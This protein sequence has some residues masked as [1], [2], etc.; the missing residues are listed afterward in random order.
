[1]KTRAGSVAFALL[2]VGVAAC[3]GDGA[4]TTSIDTTMPMETTMA[5]DMGDEEF[6]FG[7]PMDGSMADRVVEITANDDFTFAPATIEVAN[8]EV[9]TF[10]VTNTGS[11]PHD[12]VLGDAEAQDEHAAEMAEM[13]A[14]MAHDEANVFTLAPGET[15]ELTWHFTVSGEVIYGCHQPG[16]YTAGM[17]GTVTVAG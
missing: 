9:V 15:K 6:A 17:K 11:I 12:F 1:M 10:R 2:L 7:A 13:G 8:G 14:G 3:G 16:H 4:S 5:H